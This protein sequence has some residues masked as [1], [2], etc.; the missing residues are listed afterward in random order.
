MDEQS[1]RITVYISIHVIIWM[2]KVYS[3][4]LL[5]P[6]AYKIHYKLRYNRHIVKHFMK[7][8]DAILPR[9]GIG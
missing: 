9:K 7:L 1:G 8:N 2:N 6:H 5:P 4:T 3:Q